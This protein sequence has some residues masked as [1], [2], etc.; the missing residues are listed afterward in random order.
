VGENEEA[1]YAGTTF[2][3]CISGRQTAM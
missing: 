2:S 3:L 1:G